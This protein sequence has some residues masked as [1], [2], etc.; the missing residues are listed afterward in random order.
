MK[1][2]HTYLDFLYFKL[3]TAVPLCLVLVGFWKTNPFMILPYTLWIGIH[4]AIV[5]RILCTHCPHYGAYNGKTQCLCLW[6][7]PPF[8]QARPTPQSIVEKLGV[9]ILLVI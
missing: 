4:I 7:I 3:F 6:A 9:K 1:N 5:Y 2:Q 8:Y